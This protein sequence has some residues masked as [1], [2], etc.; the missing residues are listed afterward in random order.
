MNFRDFLSECRDKDVFKNLSIYVVSSWVILQAVSLLAAPLNLPNSSLTVLLLVLLIAFP[1]YAFFLWQYR[2]KPE[3][4]LIQNNFKKELEEVQASSKSGVD[5]GQA[6]RLSEIE[7]NHKKFQ[8]KYFISVFVL[9]ILSLSAS[10][11]IV[12]TN[13]FKPEVAAAMPELSASKVSD[14]IAVLTFDNNTGDPDF[15]IVGK[16]AVD[17]IMHGITQNKIGQVISPK[18]IEDYSEVVKASMVS[19]GEGEVMQKYLKPS[20]VIEGS[21]YK[22]G[23]SLLFQSSITD[24]VMERTLVS[25][26]P[27]E[28][29]AESPLDCIEEMKQRILG[30][31]VTE[32]EPLENLQES[33]PKYEAYEYLLE[34]KNRYSDNEQYLNLLQKAI[35]SDSSFFEAKVS[36][37][38]YYYNYGDK[39][40]A[41]SIVDVL[42]KSV[43]NNRRQWN[44]LKMY[45]AL[46]DGDNGGTYKYLRN[47]YD[48]NPF[49]IETN[50][51]LMT[52]ALACVNRPGD[53]EEIFN[54]INVFSE[55]KSAQK[56]FDDCV[57]CEYRYR[58]KGWS[59]IELNNYQKAI[60]LLKPF[61]QSRGYIE[62]K[63]V[64]IRAYIRSGQSNS[65]VERLVSGF[66]L[67]ESS[68]LPEISL[69]AGMDYCYVKKDSLAQRFLMRSI[70]AVNKNVA[71]I[72]S[73][74]QK[75]LG[76]AYLYL[77]DYE[78]ASKFLERYVES[79]PLKRRVE[80]LG[81]L[82]IAYS[83][84]GNMAKANDVLERLEK[85]RRP[86]MYGHVDYAFAQ[87][88]GA[89][90]DEEKMIRHLKRA[91]AD[92]K[93]FNYE[94]F[95]NDIFF[96]PYKDKAGF[97]EILAYWH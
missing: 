78:K 33:P 62:L 21:F 66:D 72:D 65:N 9:G 67:A 35:A 57:Q 12:K 14:K 8:R 84:N 40:V 26:G 60:D 90:D 93:W 85:R 56:D 80:H 36:L 82:A 87:F 22:K 37:L 73:D 70:D 15:E 49:N 24:E 25:L 63:K 20:K 7:S 44:L 16:M 19:F 74:R 46:L 4:V 88:Y 81:R 43:N 2:I 38:E 61:E 11:F 41:D 71:I 3:N 51:S 92:G 29:N 39:G 45:E 30:F 95:N 13:F 47:E 77:G 97:Q 23:S 52:V 75:L 48:I 68:E 32:E 58:Q 59:E 53:I 10:A 64:L 76:T 94:S 55:L 83:K 86:Y 79:D 18:I 34:A 42:S 89:I 5:I 1:L 27:I 91:V 17:W 54:Q 96:L 50:T 28:C 69:F 31:L 6:E